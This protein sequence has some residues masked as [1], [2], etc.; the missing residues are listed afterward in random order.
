MK[1]LSSF[2]AKLI[3][4]FVV[5]SLVG[6]VVVSTASY[7]LSSRLLRSEVQE[8]LTSDALRLS[9]TYSAWLE[10]QIAQLQ[11]IAAT[12]DFSEWDD[13]FYALLSAEYKRLGYNSMAPTDLSGILHLGGG[14]KADLSSRAYL[15]KVLTTSTPAI[16]DP[17]FS[18]VPGEENLFT[19]LF[20]VPVFRKGKLFCTLVAQRNAEFLSSTISKISY[21]EGTANYVLTSAGI[22][23]AHTDVSEVVDRL[24]VL[25]AAATDPAFASRA[26][27]T[28]TMLENQSGIVQYEYAGEPLIAGFARIP[29][30]DCVAVVTVPSRIAE[31]PLDSLKRMTVI[32]I[33]ISLIVSFI[34]SSLF[35]TAFT[36]PIM[37]L[38][39]RFSAIASGEADLTHRIEY[40]RKDEIG[41]AIY[42]FNTFIERLHG[43]ILTMRKSQE[44]L[45]SIS[46]ELVANARE[47]ASAVHEIS[48]NIESS[49]KQAARQSE[50]AIAVAE[51]VNY[52][53]IGMSKL[54]ELVET[55]VSG[56]TEVAASVEQ[57][58]GNIASVTQSVNRMA[59]RF[60][61]LLGSADD[62]RV[63]QEAVNESVAAIS[64][65]SVELMEANEAISSI[66]AQTNLLAM[67]AAIEA[68]HAGD[69]G[70]GFSV[71]ADEIRK[72]S[73]N[74]SEQSN[75]IGKQLSNISSSIQ[76]VVA[77]SSES[78]TVFAE[79]AEGVQATGSL[80]NQIESA[81]S[82]Q[83]EGSRQ[84]LDALRDMNAVGADVKENASSM[85][86]SASESLES[87]KELSDLSA[88][89]RNSMDEMLAGATQIRTAAQVVAN[90]ANET[91]EH[92]GSM[93]E[94]IGQFIV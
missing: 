94:K 27:A 12:V 69:A 31:A 23:V 60:K 61:V 2:R 78:A 9:E 65:Q 49:R 6:T 81:M 54:D 39:D 17:V 48:S 89:I 38:S 28:Q 71:V 76:G 86:R 70:K 84:I 34:V 45:G 75:T 46:S 20:A 11:T 74:A 73:E 40:R 13:D 57:M 29:R 19:V 55:Q 4:G 93:N 25:K 66:A 41:T 72:L 37:L 22:P 51:A 79:I 58:V 88:E 64:R 63:R 91:G 44:G 1:L 52:I 53:S 3:V 21:G 5:L 83:R 68:A 36:K 14:R 15:Q 26:R 32:A 92:V 90:L 18:N 50:R 80:V 67:N 59:D 77:A 35:G 7:L 33:L 16:S 47:S 82:E 10:I 8:R 43:I 62:G 30:L 85:K 87:M 24:D 56:N 42:G